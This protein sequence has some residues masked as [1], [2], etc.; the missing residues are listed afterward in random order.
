[1]LSTGISPETQAKIQL[2]TAHDPA[3]WPDWYRWD[4]GW[5]E[6]DGENT[7]YTNW[8]DLGDGAVVF[9]VGAYEGEWSRRMAAKYTGYEIHAF[10][11]APRAFG[12]AQKRLAEYSNVNLYNLALGTTTKKARLYDAQRDGATLLQIGGPAVDVQIMDFREFIGQESI[13]KIHLMSLNVEGWEFELLPYL[14]SSNL[15]GQIERMMIQWHSA[16][17]NSREQQF[18]IQD[19]LARTHRMSWNHGAWEAWRLQFQE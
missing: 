18:T 2:W 13:Q 11:P 8:D 4:G 7:R 15:I 16:N 12:V 9:D 6:V 1:V 5:Y 19:V 3:T 14:I 17:A 10:E